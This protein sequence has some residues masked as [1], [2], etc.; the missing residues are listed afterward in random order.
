MEPG[1][2]YVW[3][4]CKQNPVWSSLCLV[5]VAK[6]NPCTKLGWDMSFG[7]QVFPRGWGGGDDCIWRVCH[8]Q[9]IWFQ[10]SVT[11]VFPKDIL[12]KKTVLQDAVLWRERL[13]LDRLGKWHFGTL[14][15]HVNTTGVY[16]LSCHP[17][18]SISQY[19]RGNL[20]RESHNT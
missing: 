19:C 1:C 5:W 7:F 20:K 14:A 6:H 11:S 18:N 10:H 15:E 3:G 8:M 9:E 13:W 12:K 4:C 16:T 2:A 17:L